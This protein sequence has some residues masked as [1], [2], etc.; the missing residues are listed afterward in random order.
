MAA[1]KKRTRR[2]DRFAIAFIAAFVGLLNGFFLLGFLSAYGPTTT[3]QGTLRKIEVDFDSS[4]RSSGVRDNTYW[5]EGTTESG[6]SWRFASD[7]AYEAAE[8]DGYPMPVEVT[9]SDWADVT[10]RVKGENFDD[11]HRGLADRIFLTGG[12]FLL[13]LGA[14]AAAWILAKGEHGV[15][16]AVIV[17]VGF[18][19]VG[20]TLGLQLGHWIRS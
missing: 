15:I 11:T 9:F 18:F 20:S 6:R 12:F 2:A 4:P 17:L 16:G 14:L 13:S 10:V 1:T 3:E 19:I 7:E 8:R 5:V